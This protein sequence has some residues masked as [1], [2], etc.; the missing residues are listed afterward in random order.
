MSSRVLCIGALILTC[1]AGLPATS[2]QR[3]NRWALL[4]TEVALF[5]MH[6]T[7][8]CS[9]EP[10]CTCITLLHAAGQSCL[11]RNRIVLL[12]PLLVENMSRKCPHMLLSRHCTWLLLFLLGAVLVGPQLTPLF[13]PAGLRALNLDGHAT[14]EAPRGS[15]WPCCQERLCTIVTLVLY[16]PCA[17]SIVSM[18]VDPRQQPGTHM[19]LCE[20]QASGL[21]C[22]CPRMIRP[23]AVALNSPAK[24][25]VQH[26][27]L[28]PLLESDMCSCS[29]LLFLLKS[30]WLPI[31]MGCSH[32]CLANSERVYTCNSY[33]KWL[34]AASSVLLAVFWMFNQLC[35][36]WRQCIPLYATVQ[37]SAG[38]PFAW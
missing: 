32:A 16:I 13:S 30:F 38:V 23:G 3:I 4:P 36:W 29:A 11:G 1:R 25:G 15:L 2:Q 7:M 27:L 33:G 21:L 26:V 35:S 5:T 37:S 18:L 9:A 28:W 12:G 34:S 22:S 19:D 17:T 6:A 24:P 8:L 10:V 14:D 31:V 20:A